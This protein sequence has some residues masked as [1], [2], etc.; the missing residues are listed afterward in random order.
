MRK[1]LL[2]GIRNQTY[3]KINIYSAR[4]NDE[5]RD[6]YRSF[7]IGSGKKKGR[8]EK[9]HDTEKGTIVVLGI[10]KSQFRSPSDFI[11]LEKRAVAAAAGFL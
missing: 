2:S 11:I 1:L 3:R 8:D 6:R 9:I 5:F 10:D 7:R 4:N